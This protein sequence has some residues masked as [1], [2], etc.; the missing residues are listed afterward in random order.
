MSK[1]TRIEYFEASHEEDEGLTDSREGGVIKAEESTEG[2]RGTPRKRR[3]RQLDEEDEETIG[4]QTRRPYCRVWT[5]KGE[6][7]TCDQVGPAHTHT[8]TYIYTYIYI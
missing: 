5:S 8:S 4:K 6:C 7:F 1:V 3:H 2:S